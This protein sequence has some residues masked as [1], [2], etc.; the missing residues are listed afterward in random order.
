MLLTGMVPSIYA[1]D[2]ESMW[3]FL[4]WDP[5][6]A[7]LSGHS[8]TRALSVHALFCSAIYLEC[9]REKVLD[10]IK[11]VSLPQ[12]LPKSLPLTVSIQFG[13]GVTFGRVSLSW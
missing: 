11:G 3:T 9:T 5:I 8:C 6:C 7:V 10:E 1:Y 12:G 13:A 2:T 4:L